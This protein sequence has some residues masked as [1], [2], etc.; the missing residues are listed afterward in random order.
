MPQDVKVNLNMFGSDGFAPI[1]AAC[2]V[3][4]IE[5]VNYLIFKKKA[6]PN[7]R[8]LDDQWAPLEI[9]CWS[10]HPRIVDILLKDSRT[11]LNLTHPNRGSC[12]HLAAKA[13]QFQIVQML[14]MQNINFGLT[15]EDGRKA[16]D[17]TESTKILNVINNYEKMHTESSSNDKYG[18][19]AQIGIIEEEED[20]DEDNCGDSSYN[21]S[22]IMTA[23]GLQGVESYRDILPKTNNMV[24]ESQPEGNLEDLMGGETKNSMIK[25]QK[26]LSKIQMRL[27]AINND[28]DSQKA[29]SSMGGVKQSFQMVQ[30]QVSPMNAA[31]I[32]PQSQ[33]SAS[34]NM[35]S[36]NMK[37]MV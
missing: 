9:A 13:D 7:L 18:A 37:H 31:S 2:S 4:N 25:S 16:K 17:I 29:K 6:D 19:T 1:H 28:E 11:N 34:E 26:P 36:P 3:G 24:P 35:K 10:G 23:D 27:R 30:T 32:E 22:P 14:L 20:E 21:N 33:E 8:A 15:T 12:L 5:I